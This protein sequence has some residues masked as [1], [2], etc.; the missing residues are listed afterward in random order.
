MKFALTR[1]PLAS[2]PEV[3]GPVELPDDEAGGLYEWRPIGIG[4]SV[5]QYGDD[6]GFR[7]SP[8]F[9]GAPGPVVELDISMLRGR[10]SVEEA[11]RAVLRRPPKPTSCVRYFRVVR[12]L[13]TGYLAFSSP[14][15]S[16][17]DH[18]SIVIGGTEIRDSPEYRSKWSAA[19]RVPLS[20]VCDQ[21]E[22]E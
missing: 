19:D 15:A 20:D 18:V 5:T 2:E 22:G 7:D 1:R 4:E 12:L 16:N 9:E 17:P 10:R 11:A 21:G 6:R 3:P 14:S 8:R 13:S